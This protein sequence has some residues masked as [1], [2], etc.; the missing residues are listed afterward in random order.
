MLVA[1][2]GVEPATVA[3]GERCAIQLRHGADKVGEDGRIRTYN[4]AVQS[5]VHR[6]LCYVPAVVERFAHDGNRTRVL[7]LTRPALCL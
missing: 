4:H 5:R 2:A 7:R 6:R 1:P 3:L